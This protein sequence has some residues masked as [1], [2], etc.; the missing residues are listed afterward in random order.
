MNSTTRLYASEQA[1]NNPAKRAR[2]EKFAMLLHA[3]L[4]ARKRLMVTFNIT[5]EKLETLLQRLPA[6]RAPTVSPLHHSSGYA[7]QI[8]V[9]ANKIP[10]LIPQIKEEG[11]TDIVVTNIKM[12]IP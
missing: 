11:G 3:V 9:E 2:I 6:A 8:A 10:V 7:I 5:A 12:L 4:D 1:W